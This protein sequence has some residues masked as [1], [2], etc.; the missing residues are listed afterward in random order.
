MAVVTR[1]F[2]VTANGDG[3]GSTWADRAALFSGGA[4]SSVITGFDFS[5]SDSL[6]CLI[7]PGTHTIT[8]TLQSSSFSVAA[9]TAANPIILHGCDSN[10]AILEPANPDWVSAQPCDW[11]SGLPVLATTSNIGTIDLANLAAVRLLAFSASGRNGTILNTNTNLMVY[12]WCKFVQSTSNTSAGILSALSYH[13]FENCL[14]SQSGD[15]FAQTL[16]IL[17]G[18]LRN[19][20]FSGVTGQGGNRFAVLHSG[21]YGNTN[22]S[23]LVDGCSFVGFGGGG[24]VGSSTNLGPQ[25]SIDRSVVYGCGVGMQTDNDANM[26]G[27]NSVLRSVVVGNGTYGINAQSA[28]RVVVAASRLRDNTSGNFNGLGNYPTN[29]GNIVSAGT[30]AAEFVDAA[31]GDYR[32]KYGSSL[33]GLGI[34]A[35][36]EPAPAGGGGGG[37]R[38]RARVLA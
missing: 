36:D 8:A 11:D 38:S 13:V 14:F 6:L 16:N 9:P 2:G 18:S 27:I 22:G 17:Q 21:S 37:R 25:I 28:G 30:D 31:A 1:Y 35:G 24:V 26:T 4:W 23:L 20:R 29:L 5:G 12:D 15:Y 34:G 3:D 7:G 10:G 32:I 19:C 33:W